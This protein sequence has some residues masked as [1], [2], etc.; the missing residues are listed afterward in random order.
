MTA[1]A[2]PLKWHARAGRSAHG[3]A[4]R[5]RAKTA[6]IVKP[7]HLD[8]GESLRFRHGAGTWIY[9]IG[10]VVW[11]TEEGSP[12]DHVLTPGDAFELSKLGTAIVHA[13]WPARLVVKVPQGVPTPCTVVKATTDDATE[14]VV[15]L[16]RPVGSTV[17]AERESAFA[18][19]AR[20]KSIAERM[21]A[22]F[23]AAID[24]LASPYE[25]SSDESRV[26]DLTKAPATVYSDG[27]PPRHI[28]RQAL[29]HEPGMVSQV[30]NEE[31][32]LWRR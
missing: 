22:L 1:A 10:G 31:Y 24:W 14:L 5:R 27:L 29:Q 12:H 4:R 2:L 11:I 9:A 15:P 20:E 25:R 28:R 30:V 6:P 16:H 8:R 17:P 18:N 3:A 23:Q 13:H 7:I 26:I 32:L 21:V 19:E